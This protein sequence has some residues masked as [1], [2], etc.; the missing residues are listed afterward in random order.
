MSHDSIFPHETI[1]SSSWVEIRVKKSALGFP[2][3]NL[4]DKGVPPKNSGN[5]LAYMPKFVL[6]KYLLL[7]KAK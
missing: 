7:I 4:V 5:V 6:S 1:E 3:H 2:E